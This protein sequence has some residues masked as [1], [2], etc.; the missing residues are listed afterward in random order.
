MFPGSPEQYEAVTDVSDARIVAKQLLW[1]ATTPAAANQAFNIANGD[2]FRWRRMWGTVAAALGVEAAPYPGHPQPLAQQMADA[3]PIWD[4]I[5][6]QHGLSPTRSTRSP[7]G[8]TPTPTSAAR[9][10]P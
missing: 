1:A 4:R 2:V 10:K 9:S 7:R 3:G 6:Q 5:V 8:G